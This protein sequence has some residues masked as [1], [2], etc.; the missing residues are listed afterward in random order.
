MQFGH[1]AKL[2]NIVHEFWHLALTFVEPPAEGYDP[3]TD[4]PCLGIL[5]TDH[6][7]DFQ[8]NSS[9]PSDNFSSSPCPLALHASAPYK[10]VQP[11]CGE[12]LLQPVEH[13]IVARI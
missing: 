9:R 1:S 5:L 6:L 12:A 3:T 11:P 13:S 7:G 4:S 10:V 2:V 8:R